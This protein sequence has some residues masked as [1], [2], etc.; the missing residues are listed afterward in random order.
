MTR[1]FAY[2][3]NMDPL[4]MEQRWLGAV[5]VG[6]ARLDDH[7][8]MFAWDSPGWGGGVATVEPAASDHVWGVLWELTD[9]H[10]RALDEYEGV[11]KGVY[12][13]ETSEVESAG[14]MVKAMIYVATD[15][16]YKKPSARYVNAL[17]RG[18]KAFAIPDEYV[19]RLRA[20]RA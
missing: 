11:S 6:P 19:E 15:S 5:V 20:L 18:A 14:E 13:R 9:E 12:T 8:L 17:I 3:S 10:V 16:R 7:R 4:Q 2:G 1:Y